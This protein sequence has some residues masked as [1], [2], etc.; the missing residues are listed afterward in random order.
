MRPDSRTRTQ[1]VVLAPVTD[2]VCVVVFCTVGRRSHAEG[3]SVA[4]T[5][6]TAWP[7]LAGNLYAD[8]IMA[9]KTSQTR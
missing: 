9:T 1:P 7:F 5:A 6:E 2:I 8:G 4:G 3:L